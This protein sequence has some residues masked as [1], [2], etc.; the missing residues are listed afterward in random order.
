M[1]SA[2]TGEEI[3]VE[4][5]PSRTKLPHPAREAILSVAAL[6]LGLG[7]PGMAGMF[8][9][10]SYHIPSGPKDYGYRGVGA[11]PREERQRRKGAAPNGRNGPCSCGSGKKAKKCCY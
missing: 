3:T 6:G 9:L 8:N 7:I 1:S 10:G 5:P 4:I 11:P 2:T